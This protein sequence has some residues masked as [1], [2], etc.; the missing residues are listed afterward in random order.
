[1]S[2]TNRQKASGLLPTGIDHQANHIVSGNDILLDQAA[3][4]TATD[5]KG[6]TALHWAALNPLRFRP[7]S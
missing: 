2:P 4:P 5:K 7:A 6:R 1:M 3:N